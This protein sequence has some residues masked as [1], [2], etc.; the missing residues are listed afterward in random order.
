[1]NKDNYCII[2]A[3][4]RGRRLWPCSRDKYPKQF[5]DLFGTGRTQLQSTYDRF[6]KILPKENI[7]LCT[8]T[9]FAGIVKEQLPDLTDGNIIIEPI[10][11]NTGACVAWAV[12]TIGLR[13]VEANI[14]VSPSDELVLNEDAFVSNLT[15]GLSLVA[16]HNAMLV[17]GVRPT[18]PEPGYGYIQMGEPTDT[19]DVYKV[20]SFTEK[21]EREFATMFIESGEFFWNTGMILAN[22][23]V[24]NSNFVDLFPET[25]ELFRTTKPNQTLQDGID[26][27][28][29]FY[30][31]FPNISIDNAV[32]ERCNNVYVMKCD[33]GWADLGTWHAIY[34]CMSRTAD[35]NVV[36]D[37]DVILDDCQ[38]NIIKLPKG[39]LGVINGL[40]GFIVAEKDNVILICKKGD[41]SSLVKKYVNEVG[42][43]FG[44]DFI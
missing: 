3:G 41:S 14:I 28:R 6:C 24:F 23:K 43:K 22:F 35:D 7:Y 16:T 30:S 18:R 12:M 5:I 32:L 25:L 21:P 19:E 15:R 42:M 44:D 39:K 36:L 37:S 2:L 38:N 31:L 27:T 40:K 10:N 34:E 13:N 33:F 29:E 1:M 4:G 9:E 11:R 20:Q 17:M 8:N 26:F